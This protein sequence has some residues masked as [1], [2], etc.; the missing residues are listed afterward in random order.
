[1]KDYYSILGLPH[2]CTHEEIKK[3]YRQLARNAHPDT[4]GK[5]DCSDFRE[6]Q[7]AYEVICNS[8]KRKVY[9]SRLKESQNRTENKSNYSTRFGENDFDYL[10]SFESYFDRLFNHLINED[11]LYPQYDA[12]NYQLELILTSEEARTGGVVPVKIPLREQ[13]PVCSGSG[14]HLFF[15]CDHCQGAGY[16]IKDITVKLQ[17]PP[18]VRNYSRFRIPIHQY[19]VLNITLIIH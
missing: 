4:A 19:G 7:E 5:D 14:S 3:A 13:C 6:I 11:S 12:V 8:E 15:F 17:I 16:T 18:H 1:M 9:D 2:N 10:F